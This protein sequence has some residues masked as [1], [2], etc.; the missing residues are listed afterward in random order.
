MFVKE[1]EMAASVAR[2]IRA[3]GMVSRPEFITPWGVCDL[4][5]LRFSADKVAQ[6]LGQKQKRAISSIARAIVLLHIPDVE[7]SKYTTLRTLMNKCAPS[8]PEE[9]VGREANRLID[10]GFVVCS[11]RGRLQKL[12]GW[13]PL[14]ERMI[15]VELKLSR[16]E[17]ALRQGLNNLGF[18]DESYVALPAEVAH[19]VALKPERW[20]RFFDAGVGILSVE[21][22]T[23]EIVVPATKNDDWISKAL[24]MYCVEKFWTA[25]VKDN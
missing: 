14:Q 6:R 12:N 20:S 9:I 16:I 19:R 17:E 7:S 23:C 25:Y 13:M 22:R 10:D 11:A 18:V 2:W 3:D 1:R 21:P 15:A 24:Q 8:I 4:V 5:G